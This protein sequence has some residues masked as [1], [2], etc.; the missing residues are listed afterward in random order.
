MSD[1]FNTFARAQTFL[2]LQGYRE[3]MEAN[4]LPVKYER[5]GG[6]TMSIHRDPDGTLFEIVPY[7]SDK[8]IFKLLAK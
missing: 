1:R 7:P 6:P 4:N 3:R 2:K 5:P 8:E